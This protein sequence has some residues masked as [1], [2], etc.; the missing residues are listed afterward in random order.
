MASKPKAEGEVKLCSKCGLNPRSNSESTNPWC[1]QCWADYLRGNRR[2]ELDRAR[3]AG[4]A[5]GIRMM[6]DAVAARFAH[7]PSAHFSGTE[8]VS[9]VQTMDAPI[10]ARAGN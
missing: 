7:W 2:R 9:Q 8:V 4:R 3:A 1:R 5:E 10:A 6:R